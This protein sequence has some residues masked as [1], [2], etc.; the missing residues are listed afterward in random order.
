MPPAA[1]ESASGLP[2]FDLAQW[3]GQIVWA[4]ITFGV[5]YLL[6]AKVFL[7]RIGGTID[8]REDRISGEIGE[9]RRMRDEAVAKSAEAASE[10]AGARA[11]ARKLADEAI[12]QVKAAGD[13]R[14]SEEDEALAKI[15]STAEARIGLARSEA[16]THLGSIAS[17]AAG[18]MIGRLTG[19]PPAETE[20]A[21]AFAGHEE[22]G[23]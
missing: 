18:A 15:L 5:L 9:A 6:L 20:L 7:P 1:P 12:A 10:M 14:R 4:L 21:A 17:V 16:M 19:K 13:A 23:S 3:P 8:A 2:Q 11:R 22:G